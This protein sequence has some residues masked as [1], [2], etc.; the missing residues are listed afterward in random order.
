MSD[1]PESLKTLFPN[2][3]LTNSVLTHFNVQTLIAKLTKYVQMI[4]LFQKL[5]LNPELTKII[6][7]IIKSEVDKNADPV[8]ILIQVLQPIFGLT[9]AEIDI[10]K[11]QATFLKD[12]NHIVGIPLS[13][14]YIKSAT[15]WIS[16]KIG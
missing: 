8:D 14:K 13:K 5:R 2:A 12:N 9:T 6:L 7:N 3:D 11:Q 10:I 4:P 15:R 1:P 16:R